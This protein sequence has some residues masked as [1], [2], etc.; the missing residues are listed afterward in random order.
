MIA[1]K[2]LRDSAGQS[3]GKYNALR[4]S[5]PDVPNSGAWHSFTLDLDRRPV[6]VRGNRAE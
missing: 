6:V 3:I 2:D 5:R 4:K 1:R